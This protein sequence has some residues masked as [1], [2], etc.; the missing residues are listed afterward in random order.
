MSQ[1]I[2]A[3]ELMTVDDMLNAVGLAGVLAYF[4]IPT[5]VA[6]FCIYGYVRYKKR[7]D[8]KNRQK[9]SLKQQN[10]EKDSVDDNDKTK[11]EVKNDT[12]VNKKAYKEISSS[13]LV[14]IPE[15]PENKEKFSSLALEFDK[16]GHVKNNE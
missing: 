14:N 10:A 5:I 15:Q 1:L 6:I 13:A 11:K 4:F 8:L 3:P 9:L 16:S 12:E 2:T 7:R